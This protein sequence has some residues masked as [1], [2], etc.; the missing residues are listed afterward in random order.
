MRSHFVKSGPGFIGFY[1]VADEANS[2]NAAVIVW[3]SKA[4]ADAF[5]D[6]YSSRTHARGAPGM[7]TRRSE[8][9]R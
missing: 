8:A 4:H 2:I 3:V 9:L 1:V 6:V 7:R 5:D